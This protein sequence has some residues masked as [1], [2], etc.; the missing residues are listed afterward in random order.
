MMADGAPLFED[1]RADELI[2][3]SPDA[4]A[5]KCFGRGGHNFDNAV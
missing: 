3:Y 5:H 1:R 2:I 4:S